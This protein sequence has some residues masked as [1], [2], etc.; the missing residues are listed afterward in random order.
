VVKETTTAL[1]SELKK[2]LS[3]QSVCAR[4]FNSGFVNMG[5]TAFTVGEQVDASP[6]SPD[7]VV[8]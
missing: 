1:R 5:R 7:K 8:L 3:S 4:E 6:S 2:Y